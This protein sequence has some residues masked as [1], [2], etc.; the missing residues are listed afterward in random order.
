MSK[1]DVSS[2]IANLSLAEALELRNELERHIA[3]LALKTISQEQL[4]ALDDGDNL[5]NAVSLASKASMI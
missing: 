3:K 1:Q 5:K 2:K 4:D